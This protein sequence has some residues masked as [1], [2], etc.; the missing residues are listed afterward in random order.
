MTRTERIAWIVGAAGLVLAV[1][2]WILA[3]RD[4]A[5]GWLAAM[6]FW[7]GWPLGGIALILVHALTGGQWGEAARPGLLLGVTTLALLPPALVPYLFTAT[8]LYPWLHTRELANHFYLNIPF[9]AGRG[10]VYLVIWFAL[11]ALVLRGGGL[12]RLAPP[13]LFLLAFTVTF[14]EIDTVM[15]LDPAFRSSE[16][17][18]VAAAAMAL[19]A[20][21]FAVLLAAFMAPEPVLP[22]LGKL[23]LGL[24]VLWAYLEFMQLL[25]VWE[26]NL[27][28]DA[29]WYA[30][31]MH[32]GWGVALGAIAILHFALPFALLIFPRMQ[33]SRMALALI[34][35][36]LILAAA[37]RCWWLVLPQGG[38]SV[39]WVDIA[40]LLAY[41]GL[42]LGLAVRAANSP[43][44]ARYRQRHV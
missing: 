37:L 35:L 40:C 8:H 44:L 30:R 16:F 17:G 15:S 10:V 3:P 39:G 1:L 38:R 13:G 27:A 25:I 19:L 22:D 23:V 9:A 42:A 5:Y 29:P 2:G 4:F 18:M 7:I 24:V 43:A 32:G 12:L 33:R 31:R 11:A 28:S 36:L 34:A 21:S 20:L 6:T 14:A 41:G 26:S